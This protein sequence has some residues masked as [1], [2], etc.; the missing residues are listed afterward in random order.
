[1][2]S[3]FS[4]GWHDLSAP[5]HC[6]FLLSFSAAIFHSQLKALVVPCIIGPLPSC[7]ASTQLCRHARRQASYRGWL[8]INAIIP[9]VWFVH[10]PYGG[11]SLSSSLAILWWSYFWI[12][13]H[14]TLQQ[15]VCLFC[16]Y[17]FDLT[18]SGLFAFL[19]VL[20]HLL[21]SKTSFIGYCH[22]LLQFDSRHLLCSY[23]VLALVAK[24]EGSTPVSN[25]N[26]YW[27]QGLIFL[28]R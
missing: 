15:Q 17:W 18:C 10:D 14:L 24:R 19:C 6:S 16:K 4:L 8:M 23:F 9:V 11:Y 28:S 2:N 21:K 13:F 27:S 1:M 3:A 7:V 20:L 22:P 12:F 26:V 25:M 5:V